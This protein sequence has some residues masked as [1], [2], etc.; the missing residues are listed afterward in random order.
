[1]EHTHEHQVAGGSVL[2]VDD[3]PQYLQA[4]KR[5]LG[6]R[7]YQVFLADDGQTA[8]EVARN[9]R[10]DIILL[11]VKM[12]GMDG[13]QTCRHLKEEAATSPI[14]VIFISGEDDVEAKAQA[15]ACGGVDYITK[16][17]H[18][19]EVLMRVAT[20]LTLHALQRRLE[21]RVGERTAELAITN[22]L[23][24]HEIVE[25]RQ[26]EEKFRGVLESAPDAM[27][28]VN[29]QREIILVNSRTE[30]LFGYCREELLGQVIELLIPERYRRN[31]VA[32]SAGY[33]AAPHPRAMCEN[34]AL[35]GRRCDGSEFPVEVSLSPL[36]LPE[37]LFV[38]SAI[39]DI[40]TRKE[41]EAAVQ[42]LLEHRDTVREE[43]RKRIAG[44]VHD[45]LGSLLT[46]L[47]ID[48]SLLRMQLPDDAPAQER[49]GQMRELIERTIH[50]VRQVA[51]QLRP[52]AL[53]LGLVPA[54]EWLV[55]DFRRRTGLVCTFSTDAEVV[56]DDAHATA[57]FRIIQ[58]SLTNV[59]RHAE[60]GSVDVTLV[61]TDGSLE[62]TVADD[63]RGFDTAAIG[64]A[65]FGLLG[66]Y[67][68]VRSL[69][70]RANVVSAP[71]QGTRVSI[72]IPFAA[73]RP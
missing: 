63:G 30:A 73:A 53:N 62:L 31:H 28:I 33:I 7:G 60:A 51:T 35:F 69:G 48:V 36:N 40:S 34:L 65:P 12:P 17:F 38:I 14:P 3:M 55:E 16:P 68:R 26:T 2:V 59:A 66:I 70:G 27:V 6:R 58:E 43:E 25:R 39:R 44:E 23:L 4:L 41:A 47:K 11:D 49:V 18:D 37:G 13:Y 45:E 5:L 72:W 1:M 61:S 64:G 10:P 71:G 29:A 8:L 50:M 54:L 22:A 24:Q 57:I 56:M 42:E 19:A 46:A 67:E 32:E 52:V 21:E 15:F 20:H 9:E